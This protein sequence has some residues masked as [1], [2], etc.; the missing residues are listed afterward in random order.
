MSEPSVWQ[1]CAGDNNSDSQRSLSQVSLERTCNRSTY[2]SC[3]LCCC[4]LWLAASL[5]AFIVLIVV[6][7]FWFV[8]RLLQAIREPSYGLQFCLVLG[9]DETTACVTVRQRSQDACLP[10]CACI[11]NAV[12]ACQ[13]KI[14]VQNRAILPEQMATMQVE[15]QHSPGGTAQLYLY[16]DQPPE[17]QGT[18]AQ[19]QVYVEKYQVL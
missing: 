8:P 13:L 10:A 19:R 9:S 17:R 7:V 4:R 2:L 16:P 11:A 5:A 3:Q 18:L 14:G 6:L 12:Y 15:Y 1:E